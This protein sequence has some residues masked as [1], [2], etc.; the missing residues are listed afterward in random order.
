MYSFSLKTR[1]MSSQFTYNTALGC[2]TYCNHVKLQQANYSVIALQNDLYVIRL[3]HNTGFTNILMAVAF[4][5]CAFDHL[6][7]Q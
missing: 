7:Q 4:E 2:L 1:F 6:K 3:L 5:R